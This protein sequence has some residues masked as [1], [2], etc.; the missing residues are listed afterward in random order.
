MWSVGIIMHILSVGKPPFHDND[1]QQLL[2]MIL[3]AS[4]LSFE[5]RKWKTRSV[6]CIE[7]VKRLVETNL[8]ARLN[9]EVAMEHN[10]LVEFS[11]HYITITDIRTCL[12]QFKVFRAIGPVQKA[13]LIY[14][15]TNLFKDVEVDHYKLVFY[16]IN[17]SQTGNLTRLEFLQA[18]W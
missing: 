9:A 17:K 6:G 14:M 2:K 5:N 4:G 12:L 11:N 8:N 1:N 18:Y 7:L 16:K 13:F 3:N 10:W 15:A